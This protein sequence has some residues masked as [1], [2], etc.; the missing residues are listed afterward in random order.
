MS[1]P[2]IRRTRERQVYANDYV[3][4]FDDDVVF[5]GGADG[6]YLRVEPAGDGPGAVILAVH[7]GRIGL[8]HSYR[9]PLQGWQWALP[10]GFAHGTDP[11]DTARAELFEEAGISDAVFRVLGHV[12]PDSGLQ[13]HRVA[14]VLA[15]V[16]PSAIAGPQDTE[17]AELRWVAPEDLIRD[18]AAGRIEDGF[19]LAVLG[20][21]SALG[22][23]P[24]APGDPTG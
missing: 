8:V 2:P 5:E 4:V 17:I 16:G 9:Y 21:A 19:T 15:E 12:T 10:R 3:R 11:I 24:S 7:E 13:S 1:D 20:L 18:V 6:R 22:V 14:V 23:L